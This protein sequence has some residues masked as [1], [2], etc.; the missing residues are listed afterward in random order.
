MIEY[1]GI[2][3]Q[4]RF[5]SDETKFIVCLIDSEQEE[6]AILAT[7]YMSYVS[8]TD[9]YHF[10]GDY[11][12]HPNMVNN[13][14]LNLMKLFWQMMKVRLFVIFLVLYLKELES[15]KQRLLLRF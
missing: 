1:V 9:K 10:F 8:L 15:N 7:G 4:I 13:F 12:V 6:K 3:K 14:K 2:I 11:V 5:Y